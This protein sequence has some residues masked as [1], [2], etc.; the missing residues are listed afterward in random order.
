MSVHDVCFKYFDFKKVKRPKTPTA[1]FALAKRVL[2]L[3]PNSNEIKWTFMKVRF[4]NWLC[5]VC[6]VNGGDHSRGSYKKKKKTSKWRRMKSVKIYGLWTQKLVFKEKNVQ[7]S[8]QNSFLVC[9]TFPPN[10][11]SF[12][13]SDCCDCPLWEPHRVSIN[14][15]WPLSLNMACTE[16]DESPH[17]SY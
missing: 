8:F 13:S 1:M 15:S 16:E 10:F 6:A 5:F 9:G 12:C 4:N 7:W 14:V 11:L 17:I 2:M 3:K